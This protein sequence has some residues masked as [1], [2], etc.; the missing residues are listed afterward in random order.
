MSDVIN[1]IYDK[2]TG[3]VLIYQEGKEWVLPNGYDLAHFENGVE[4][5]F[6]EDNQGNLYLKPNAMVITDY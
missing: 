1:V 3:K 6:T 5:V 4:P 2:E